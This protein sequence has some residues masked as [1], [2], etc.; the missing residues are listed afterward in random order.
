MMNDQVLEL[1]RMQDQ[2]DTMQDA[3]ALGWAPEQDGGHSSWNNYTLTN[4]NLEQD[5]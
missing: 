4:K 1:A 3:D 5:Q 2:S